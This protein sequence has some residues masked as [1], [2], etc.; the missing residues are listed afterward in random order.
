MD[1][2]GQ[3]LH[4]PP[5]FA[6]C[7]CGVDYRFPWD[8]LVLRFKFDQSPE[9]RMLV[10]AAQAS[11]APL[12]Q[13]FVPVPL[14][15]ERLAL[16]G[17]DQAWELARELGRVLRV[18]AEPRTVVRRFDARQQSS[19]SRRERLANLRGAFTVPP[20]RRVRLQGCHIGLVD[21]VMTTGASA[22][23]V[24]RTLLEA[25][26]ARVDLWVLARTPSPLP[27]A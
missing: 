12:P 3:C 25:G 24:T 1:R 8:R 18:P 20:A 23:E 27:S 11:H 9:L 17:Y 14:S 19:L 26:A 13:R 16:R 6:H 21:D 22:E 2:C 15:D 7:I 4:A 10:A 5:P